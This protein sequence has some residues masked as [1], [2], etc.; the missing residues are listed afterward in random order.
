MRIIILAILILA[1]N[2]CTAQMKIT[3]ENKSPNYSIKYPDDWKKEIKEGGRVFFMSPIESDEDS[4]MEN[5]NIGYQLNQGNTSIVEMNK[6]YESMSEYFSSSFNEFK[7]L[8]HKIIKVNNVSILEIV[9]EGKLKTENAALLQFTQWFSV[10]NGY[11]FT[12]TLTE[13]AGNDKWHLKGM[14][15]LNSLKFN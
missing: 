5:I 12:T 6:D 4:F 3:Y 9:Y 15:I 8:S 11:L 1:V 2:I 7:L 13:V 10:K 14:E